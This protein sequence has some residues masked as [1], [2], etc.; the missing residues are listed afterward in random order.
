MMGFME[1]KK[2][3]MTKKS[4]LDDALN[5]L[6]YKSR[7]ELDLR[8][9]LK[10]K[11]HDKDQIDNVIIQFKEKGYINDLKNAQL[12]AESL[13]QTKSYG[14][15]GIKVE[16]TKKGI[17][18]DMAEACANKV[19]AD[20][21]ELDIARVIVKRKFKITENQ[22]KSE[23]FEKECARIYRKLIRHGFSNDTVFRI[24]NEIRDEN[25]F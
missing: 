5:L 14:L 18:S 12:W 6:T 15:N 10:R 4:A 25:Q 20:V 22:M 19:Y 23:D 11:G 9:S 1:K 13:L 3:T 8:N 24:I 7:S 2:K 17:S 16:L 21:N